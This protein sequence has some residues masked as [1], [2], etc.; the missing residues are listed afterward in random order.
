MSHDLPVTSH[1]VRASKEVPYVAMVLRLDLGI[2]RDLSDQI[3]EINL[4][5]G[6]AQ[7]LDVHET[8]ADLLDALSRYFLL[9]NESFVEAAIMASL[10]LKE[11]HF[12]LLMAPRG[13]MLRKIM[14]GLNRANDISLAVKHIQES[15]LLPLNVPMLAKKVGMS[16]SSFHAHFKSILGTSPLQYQKQLRLMEAKWLLLSGHTV[17]STAFKVGYES[18]AQFGQEYK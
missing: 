13:G 1:I 10:I 5:N 7:A 9:V 6:G 4:G 14:W 8:D 12:R 17:T 2:L 11:I 16:T 15:Y 18:A 3:S